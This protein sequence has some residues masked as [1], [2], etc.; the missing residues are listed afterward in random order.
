MS[1]TT[2]IITTAL[3]SLA[4]AAPAAIA[5]PMD[6]PIRASSPAG[7]TSAPSRDLRNPDQRAPAGAV[8]TGSTRPVVPTRTPQV[9][10]GSSSPLVYIVPSLALIAMLAAATGYVRTSGRPRRSHAG[11]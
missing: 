4:I 7:T 8:A 5:M 11:V 10:G 1:R 2:R 6:G 9:D 3:A